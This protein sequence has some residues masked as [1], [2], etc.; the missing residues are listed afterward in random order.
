MAAYIEG[1]T[2]HVV[3]GEVKR[4]NKNPW[5]SSKTLD[6]GVVSKALNQLRMDSEFMQVTNG[7]KN[8]SRN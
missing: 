6:H 1:A 8:I 2:L 3:L 7:R 4:K 5:E